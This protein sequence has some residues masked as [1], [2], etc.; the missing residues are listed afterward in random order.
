[1][2]KQIAML[3]L[4]GVFLA[5]PRARADEPP[6]EPI[7]RIETGMHTAKLQRIDVDAANRYLV[8]ASDDKTAR[9][10]DL[11][12]GRLLQTLR[13]P[14]GAG[15]EG[16]LFAVAISPDGN[17][18]A[19]GG[20]TG[21]EWDGTISIYLFD[22]QSGRM[23]RRITG[24]P[25]VVFHLA[26]SPDGHS[27]AATLG[28]NNGVRVFRTADGSL[29][30]EDRDY[31]G[32]S[33]GAGWSGDGRL[34]TA[35]DDGFVRLYGAGLRLIAKA[36]APGGTQPYGIAFSP[37]GA[38]LALG[39]V[40]S[41]RVDVLSTADLSPLY[42]PDTRGVDNGNLPGVA[43]SEDGQRLFAG[44]AY[45]KNGSYVIRRWENGGHGKARDLPAAQ[46]FDLKPLHGGG[47]AWGAGNPA[48]GVLEADG[49]RGIGRVSAIADYRNNWE[50]FRLAEDGG[51]L[52]YGYEDRGKSPALFTLAAR[53]LQPMGATQ[54]LPA[55]RAPLTEATGLAVT[56]WES[57]TTPQLNGRALP[58][59]QYETSCSLAIAPDGVGFL[60]GTEW[61]L[62]FF[63]HDGTQQWSVTAPSEAWAVNIASN[64][65]VG[66]AAFGDGTIRWYRLSDGA[67]LLAFFP[68]ADRKRWVLW[69]PS[70]YYDCSPGGEDLISWHLN[71]GKDQAADFFPASKF[72][73]RFYRPDVIQKV[74]STLDES[75]AVRL[76]DAAA[77]RKTQSTSVAQLL[78]PV[79]AILSPQEGAAQS[80][81]SV[82][83]R[84]SVRTPSGDAVTAV[85][86]LVD[87]RPTAAVARDLQI[88]SA[89][90]EE[91]TM[92]VPIPARDCEIA[93]L[94][95]NKNGASEA[96]RV[97][98]VWKGKKPDEFVIQPKLY[99]LAIGI[100]NYND[101]N[102]KLDYAAKDATD[103]AAE[104][105]KQKG[106]LYRDVIA[107]V[108]TDAD[109]TKDGIL[110]G[111]DWIQHQTTS[112]DVAMVFLSGHGANDEQNRYYFIPNDFNRDRFRSTT[113]PFSE[114]QNTIQALAGKALFFVDSRH[115]GNVMSNGRTKGLADIN[116][117][118]N[119]LSSAENGAVVF[120]ASTGSQV[121]WED[122][123]WGNG[124]FTKA[125]I[126]GLDGGADYRKTG[127][128]TVNMLDLYI[129]ERVRELTGGRQ[130]PTTQKPPTVPD[131]PVAIKK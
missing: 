121:S 34:A 114:I 108:L 104:V 76:A 1:M 48:W 16:R 29:A 31:G 38:R 119:E 20:Y 12:D 28:E 6:S 11:R 39:Y 74:L 117:V 77:N 27:L 10:W 61:Y 67:E 94:A 105:G 54:Q 86:A 59:Q 8:T 81:P 125:L 57:T 101:P 64:G 62:R 127:R 93:L 40:D 84:Y 55:L 22:R 51:S 111:L 41:T 116:A 3:L 63:N 23:T 79:V 13:P 46:I 43:W 65:K 96:A 98:I 44:G 71:R 124:A 97:R 72:R 18:V 4:L 35:C 88:V 60:L 30:G 53:T 115:S 112:H 80:A 47:V 25:N 66:A 106:K 32:S 126:E 120:S 56:G 83:V 21:H 50:S 68:H 24:L 7:L 129:S 118:I 17:T 130:T 103:F 89:T 128:I 45:Q 9:V 100:S 110:D 19:C 122:P 15:A 90:G 87:G 36:K 113:L 99:V 78:P 70:G 58:L 42:A 82:S 49:T 102:L 2:M 52:T 69:T 5:A 123:K 26:F 75:E 85:R 33:Y 131:F 92:D 109:A 73:D 95:E 14:I 107:K 91:H 37:D